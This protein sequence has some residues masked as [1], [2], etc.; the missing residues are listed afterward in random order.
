MS[1]TKQRESRKDVCPVSGE[2]PVITIV[3]YEDA[4]LTDLLAHPGSTRA[5][6]GPHP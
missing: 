1:G 4:T 6:D 2:S 5:G 3:S